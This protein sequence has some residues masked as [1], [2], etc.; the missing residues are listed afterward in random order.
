MPNLRS[1][2]DGLAG[3]EAKFWNWIGFFLAGLAVIAGICDGDF[4]A[5]GVFGVPIL[6]SGR[7]PG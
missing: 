1:V 4:G 2:H 3:S 5:M 6:L 7:C